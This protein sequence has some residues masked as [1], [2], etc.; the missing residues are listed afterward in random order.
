MKKQRSEAGARWTAGIASVVVMAAAIAGLSRHVDAAVSGI[1][2]EAAA[3]V[4]QDAAIDK[5]VLAARELAWRAYF[6]GD[7]KTL[8][9]LLPP[10]F[11][12][13]NMN[14][15]P[16]ADLASTL[17]SSREF[18]DKGGRLVRLSFPE[19]RAQRFGDTVILYGRFELVLG[20][21]GA[22]RTMRG[23]LTEVFVRR[24]GKW[25]HP[26]WHLDLMT[27]APAT[28]PVGPKPS[29]QQ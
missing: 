27:P 7:V 21:G 15:V 10:S 17:D 14:D 6:A 26:G 22:E 9:G 16:F 24:E 25:W 29:A 20:A 11:I 8:S 4:D 12:G 23:R 19:T 28:A 18:R 2:M 5:D 1:G 3:P 13:I